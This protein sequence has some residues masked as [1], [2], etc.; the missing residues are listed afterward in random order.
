MEE[1]IGGWRIKVSND[2]EYTNVE[3]NFVWASIKGPKVYRLCRLHL[4]V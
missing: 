1:Q 4:S 3:P 2:L